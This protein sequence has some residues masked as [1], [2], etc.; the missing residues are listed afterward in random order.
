MG[1]IHRTYCTIR[2]KL[3]RLFHEEVQAKPLTPEQ[4][5]EWNKVV[6]S[7]EAGSY[8]PSSLGGDS[9][10]TDSSWNKTLRR[11]VKVF[12][13]GEFVLG[14]TSSFRMGQLL[15][16]KLVP[17]AIPKD[18]DLHAYM[19]TDFVDAVRKV[20]KDG[21]YAKVKD[22][23]E[24]AG[25]F[26][27]GVRGRLF[28]VEEDYQVGESFDGYDACGC[29]EAYALGVLYATQPNPGFNRLELALMA[30]A[31]HSAGVAA[32]FVYASTP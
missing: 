29:G 23:E 28:K 3:Y 15:Q 17:P 30:A 10:G 2:W 12:K 1:L 22:E 13:I 11:D 32:P 19:V 4:A 6:T 26:L 31:H 7:L 9:A 18:K 24:T 20:F 27:V 21:G 25:V 14:F 16:H 5:A 8:G